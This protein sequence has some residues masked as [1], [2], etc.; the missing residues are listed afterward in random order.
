MTPLH[1][2]RKRVMAP[3]HN[4]LTIGKKQRGDDTVHNA[5]KHVL[6]GTYTSLPYQEISKGHQASRG[7]CSKDWLILP[8]CINGGDF[9]TNHGHGQGRY[10]HRCSLT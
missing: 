3:F 8:I 9:V 10:M 2:I 4:A 5:D 7:T 6:E 1:K